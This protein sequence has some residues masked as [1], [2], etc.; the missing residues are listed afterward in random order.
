MVCEAARWDAGEAIVGG[1]AGGGRAWPEWQAAADVPALWGHHYHLHRKPAEGPWHRV[2]VLQEVRLMVRATG[3]CR[4]CLQRSSASPLAALLIESAR[5][6]VEAGSEIVVCVDVC[7]LVCVLVC[8]YICVN[9]AVGTVVVQP[10]GL[11]RV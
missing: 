8:V 1:V 5:G 10:W 3:R 4:G 7:V 11:A 9:L 2:Q 6:G